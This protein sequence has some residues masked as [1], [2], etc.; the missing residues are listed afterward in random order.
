M[1]QQPIV[2]TQ[3]HRLGKTE[4]LKR[5]KAGFQ[6]AEVTSSGRFLALQNKRCGESPGFSRERPRPD[7]GWHRRCGREDHIRLEAKPPLGSFRCWPT[8]PRGKNRRN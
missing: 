8:E 5:L 2:L 3:P 4:A 1:P 6:N 7:N